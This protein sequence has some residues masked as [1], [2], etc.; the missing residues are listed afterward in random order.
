MFGLCALCLHWEHFL[1]FNVQKQHEPRRYLN[2]D[3][4]HD[5]QG[6][7]EEVISR[8]DQDIRQLERNYEVNN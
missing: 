3:G 4:Y 2:N 5:D 6:S 8:L 7:R 1:V